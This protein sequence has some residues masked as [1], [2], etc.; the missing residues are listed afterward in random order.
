MARATTEV[1]IDL[2]KPRD[3]VKTSSVEG[4]MLEQ[5]KMR[6]GGY[7]GYH[8][9]SGANTSLYPSYDYVEFLEEVPE[10]E[11]RYIFW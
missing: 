3:H 11:I 5:I 2:F 8:T 10:M 6:M 1:S 4:E 9:E 7:Y